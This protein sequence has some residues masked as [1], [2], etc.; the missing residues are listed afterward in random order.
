MHNES[1]FTAWYEE[2]TDVVQIVECRTNDGVLAS[3]ALLWKFDD[4]TTGIDRVYP[5]DGSKAN[6]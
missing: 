3:R 6:S 5:D 1:S 4:G 2:N